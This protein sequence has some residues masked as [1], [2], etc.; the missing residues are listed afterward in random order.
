ML[1]FSLLKSHIV[2]FKGIFSQFSFPFFYRNPVYSHQFWED[3]SFLTITDG[4][5]V[6]NLSF[7]D[8][9]YPIALLSFIIPSLFFPSP[10]YYIQIYEISFRQQKCSWL[11]FRSSSHS[12]SWL[13]GK[14]PTRGNMAS[15]NTA[16]PRQIITPPQNTVWPSI[17]NICAPR[18]IIVPK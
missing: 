2:T 9:I 7:I 10:K 15:Q 12:C 16:M 5:V 17:S 8:K 18:G 14:Y 4:N 13:L 6:I 3:F 11:F 1:N